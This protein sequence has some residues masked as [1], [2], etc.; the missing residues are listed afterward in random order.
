MKKQYVWMMVTFD[1]FELPLAVA[2]TAA[3]LG[4]L[5]GQS[6]N[7]ITSAVSKAKHKGFRSRYHAVEIEDDEDPPV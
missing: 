6:S 4:K 3:E 2:D 5:V 1:E 7:A